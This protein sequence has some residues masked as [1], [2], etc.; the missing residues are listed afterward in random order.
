VRFEHADVGR[1]AGLGVHHLDH[2]AL[3]R[4]MP[5]AESHQAQQDRAEI[6][7]ALRRHILVAR[8]MFAVLPLLEEAGL[9]QRG[10]PRGQDVRCDAKAFAEFLERGV[11]VQ[12][13]A[14]D[15]HAP[16]LAR[17]APGCGRSGNAS[18]GSFSGAWST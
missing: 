12:R 9:D 15:Q 18:S 5:V 14:Q 2:R 1:L 13:I 6:A 7:P 4:E 8:R 10:K 11:A 16:P 3:R 17:P